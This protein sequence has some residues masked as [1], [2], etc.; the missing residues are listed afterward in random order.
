MIEAR[1]IVTRL[2]TVK[3]LFFFLWKERLWWLVPFVVTLLLS[4]LL[5]I[6]AHVSPVA[7]FLYTVF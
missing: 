1:G 6:F 2:S 5:L 4:A 7:Q 3:E